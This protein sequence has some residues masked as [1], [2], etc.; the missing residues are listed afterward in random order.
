MKEGRILISNINEQGHSSAK[1]KASDKHN[2]RAD[3]DNPNYVPELTKNNL[4]FVQGKQFNPEKK[5]GLFKKI[6]GICDQLKI[7][8]Q[9]DARKNNNDV[10]IS[11]Q[12]K[13]E[14]QTR[15][16][17]V[18][19]KIKKWSTNEKADDQEQAF[20]NDLYSSIGIDEINSDEKIN[21]LQSFG[22]SVKRF[23]D[24]KKAI[25]ELSDFNKLIGTKSTNVNLSIITKEIL[26]KIPDQWNHNIEPLDFLK[27]T[28]TI[29]KK[30]FPDFDPIYEIAHCDEQS[31]HIHCRLS[32]RNNKT[33]KFDI[34]NQLLNKLRELDKKNRLP[35]N[36]TYSQLS[37]KETKLFGEI[38]QEL[39][40]KYFNNLCKKYGYDFKV[41][42]RTPEEIKQNKIDQRERRK[43]S[44]EREYN[45][46]NDLAEKNKIANETLNNNKET[47]SIQN[48]VINDKKEKIEELKKE[49]TYWEKLT[50]STENA[51]KAAFEYA[52][53]KLMPDL[54]WFKQEQ[55]F[56]N[57]LNKEV[58]EAVNEQSVEM[59]PTTEQKNNIRN[60]NKPRLKM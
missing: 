47:I 20:W 24:K 57:S 3:P 27:M 36:K 1:R 28:R 5:K 32:G 45:M 6:T 60:Q 55:D 54:K 12:K 9:N 21:E 39:S 33:G 46:Q 35:E 37:K 19:S 17:K 8:F 44:A 15:R 22:K 2:V 40:I 42:K 7:D 16:T 29:N 59:Q 10:S 14:L 4:V 18:K 52:K 56:L 51:F 50:V 41:R 26:F 31:P 25:S 58:G 11:A 48:I 49:Q 23:N 38:Y 13:A 43:K 53:N 34:Q 30:F